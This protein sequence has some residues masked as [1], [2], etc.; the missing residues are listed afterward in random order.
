MMD[1]MPSGLHGVETKLK[2][3]QHK[4]AYNVINIQTMPESSAEDGQFRVLSII[5][6]V[7]L[8]TVKYIFIQ[9]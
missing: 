5:Y 3:T 9:L 7:F 4:I 2:T 6:L 1:K 8:S